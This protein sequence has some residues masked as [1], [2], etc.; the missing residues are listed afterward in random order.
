MHDGGR[1]RAFPD[2]VM[3]LKP[4]LEVV[5]HV[6]M[7]EAGRRR[8]ELAGLEHLLFALCH[9][10]ETVDVLRHSGADVESLKDKLDAYLE[11]GLEPI[12]ESVEPSPTLAFQRV[13]QRAVFHCRSAGK[14]VVGGPNVL[15]AI[16]SEP[17]C[18]A[19]SFLAQQG[20]TR[21]DVVTY[22]SH[23]VSKEQEGGAMLPADEL[24]ESSGEPAEAGAS[25][26][27]ATGPS[28]DPLSAF[29]LN[30]NE[31]AAAGLIDPLI[32]RAPEIERAVRILA[33]RRKNNPL[34]VGDSGVGKT[35]IVEGLALRVVEEKVPESLRDVTIYNLDMGLVLAGT[36]YRGDFENRFKAVLKALG[37]KAGAILFIDEIHTVIGAGSASGSSMD[38][39]NL[40]KPALAT[41][42]LRCIGSTTWQE[43]QSHF[44][45]DRALSRRFQKIELDE[46][47]VEDTIKILEGLK[48][49]YEEFHGV[50]YTHTALDA[51][52]RLSD[53]YL[54]ERKLPDKAIDL[55]DEAGAF[56]KLNPDR[57]QVGPREIEAA[58]SAMA[59]I[60]PKRVSR[61]DKE[62]LA[63]LEDELKTRV[64]G[65]EEA[66]GRLVAAIKLSR[67]G[68]REPEKPI[69]SFL[70]TGPTGV[71]KTEVARQVSQTLG[72]GFHRFDMSEYMERHT[73]SRLIGAPPGYVGFEQAGLLTDAV[74]K[75]PHCV[76]LMDE[77]EK[78]H[79]DVF[80]ILLQVMDHGTLTD[81]NGKKADFRH[82]ILIMTS[83]VGA[84]DLASRKVGFGDRTSIGEDD[85]AFR[86]TFSP[87]FRNRLD[88]RIPFNPLDLEI[89][90]KIV[91]KLLFELEAQ[92]ADRKITIALTDQARD[93]LAEKGFDP[94]MGARPLARVIQEEVKTPLGDEIL[95]G[96]LEKGGRVEVGLED[97]RIVFSF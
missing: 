96:P 22:L 34:F 69:G 29:C 84:R 5:I 10:S 6:A 33:R 97:G 61:S 37:Q 73:V 31:Q 63:T 41:G 90:A 91:D 28:K 64:F 86:R 83:N 89:M 39:S 30:L 66:I 57:K 95:F 26:G 80:N 68:L 14:E 87:E 48:S 7:S 92:L 46:P 42:K 15:V 27:G 82:S 45:K 13:I 17:E 88:A 19:V 24:D 16:F 93:Y 40:L 9:D 85:A 58:L 75:T 20:V 71:G 94:A 44:E 78:A 74:S 8:H 51:A 23:G 53:R 25:P 21:L 77:V 12:D 38:A 49:R 72:I 67:A 32:G 56:I 52:A 47:S 2:D 43:Y 65:Q 81:H 11:E 50:T 35:A 60:P 76:V 18:H 55:M 36:R 59:Q 62:R 3:K 70:F 4:E 79:P 1:V 54:Q